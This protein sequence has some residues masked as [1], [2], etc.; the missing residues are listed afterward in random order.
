MKAQTLQIIKQICNKQICPSCTV[1]GV[2]AFHKHNSLPLRQ[3]IRA[4]IAF[5]KGDPWQEFVKRHFRSSR[6]QGFDHW[7][8]DLF[9]PIIG[10]ILLRIE[11]RISSYRND[12]WTIAKYVNITYSME[13]SGDWR[14]G[15]AN[16][17]CFHKYFNEFVKNKSLLPF[18][19]WCI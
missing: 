8:C 16:I 18:G 1:S 10:S 5:C 11:P 2:L 6:H 3:Q 17:L 9:S 15:Q 12:H 13:L 7:E 19:L 14:N 4:F